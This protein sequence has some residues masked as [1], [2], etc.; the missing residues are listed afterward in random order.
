M[1]TTTFE[2]ER[3]NSFWSKEERVEEEVEEEEESAA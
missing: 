3:F 1:S 2:V